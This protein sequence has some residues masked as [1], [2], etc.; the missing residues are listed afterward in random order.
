MLYYGTGN[1]VLKFLF[2]VTQFYCDVCA[3]GPLSHGVTLQ[4]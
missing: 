3:V 1:W 4:L 2:C